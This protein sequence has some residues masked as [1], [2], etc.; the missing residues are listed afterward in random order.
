MHT[1]HVTKLFNSIILSI[2][3]SILLCNTVFAFSVTDLDIHIDDTVTEETKT[4]I[5]NSLDLLPDHVLE[6]FD[7][8]G[9]EIY[10]VDAPLYVRY[11]EIRIPS[12]AVGL[13]FPFDN[14]I[15][16]R[17][18]V[19]GLRNDYDD[20]YNKTIV[21]EMGHFLYSNT[22][23]YLSTENQTIANDNYEY[24]SKYSSD[25]YNMHETFAELYSWYIFDMMN[26]DE[27]TETMYQESE[28]I[29]SILLEND[30]EHG[31]GT[32]IDIQNKK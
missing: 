31:P 9:G 5:N 19:E 3:F 30:M 16:I 2:M 15:A 25:C 14:K 12:N 7:K 28:N 23:P 6:Y 21:H 18:D 4:M 24:W 1:H 32:E 11:P 27:S 22:Y 10:L 8:V 26:L 29:C 13:Y 20:T 17:V